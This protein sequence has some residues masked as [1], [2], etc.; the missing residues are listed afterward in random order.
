VDERGEPLDGANKYVLLF[1]PGKLPAVATFWSPAGPFN[2]T[3]R[4]YGPLP[5][6]LDGS[7][8]L[9]WVKRIG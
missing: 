7:Y 3:M 2:L 5:S 8:Q 4:F 1:D 6:V 9:P